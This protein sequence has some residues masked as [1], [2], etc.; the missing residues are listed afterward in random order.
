[1]RDIVYTKVPAQAESPSTPAVVVAPGLPA[2]QEPHVL[3]KALALFNQSGGLFMSPSQKALRAISEPKIAPQPKVKKV[4]ERG[5]TK[6]KF[7]KVGNASAASLKRAVTTNHGRL[8]VLNSVA[9]V[10]IATYGYRLHTTAVQQTGTSSDTPSSTVRRYLPVVGNA[11]KSASFVESAVDAT[12]PSLKLYTWVTPW[13]QTDVSTNRKVYSGLSA[14]WLTVNADGG[15]F[16]PQSDWSNLNAFLAANKVDGQL[17][18]LTVSGNPNAT[19]KALSD[20]AIEQQHISGLLDAVKTHGFDGIDIDYE[21]LG[22]S[23]KDAFTAFIKTLTAAF[24][25]ENKKVS[26]TLEARI[27]NQVPMDWHSLGSIVDE[28]RI[29]AY[30]YHSRATDTP[31]PVA[32]LAWIQEVTSY[33]TS[34]I[35]ANKVIIGLGNYGYDWVAP[36]DQEGSWI[37]TG[38]SQER[39]M[40]LLEDRKATLLRMTGIDE[41]GYDIGSIPSFTYVDDSGA[42]HAVWFED[43]QSMSD[44]LKI[45]S[46]FPV[47]GVIFWSVGL[48]AV[49]GSTAAQ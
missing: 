38:I 2:V 15:T 9:L 45:I 17:S 46:Q 47:K 33:A 5:K 16:T 43:Q 12:N 30:D 40:A 39:A 42:Q 19:F 8:L 28:A 41:R 37:G 23:N 48:G 14:F 34:M 13:N 25:T 1:M 20:P 31:G 32:P 35:P 27:A 24:H 21:G 36:A 44:K 10:A 4:R 29:M 18:Y 6:A 3:E 26:V 7:K 22:P 49:P 11:P